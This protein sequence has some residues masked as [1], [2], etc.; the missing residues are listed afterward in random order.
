[1][2]LLT[3]SRSYE[4]GQIALDTVDVDNKRIYLKWYPIGNTSIRGCVAMTTVDNVVFN[5]SLLPHSRERRVSTVDDEQSIYD[6][7][8]RWLYKE[9]LELS[10]PW[11]K[12]QTLADITDLYGVIAPLFGG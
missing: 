6:D 4:R 1:M 12:K 10:D 7:A 5:M 11:N 8:R 2:P 3:H 9:P